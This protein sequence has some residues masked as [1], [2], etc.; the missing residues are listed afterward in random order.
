VTSKIADIWTGVLEGDHNA[1]ERLVSHYA[2]LVF[3][4]ARKTGLAV[5]DAEDCVQQVWLALY[6]GR[7]R[8]ERPE[9]LPAWLVSTTGRKAYRIIRR[10]RTAG[11]ATSKLDSQQPE[12]PPDETIMRWQRRAQLELALEKLDSRCRKLMHAI[13]FAESDKSYQEIARE[14][15]MPLNSLGPTRARCLRKLKKILED[16]DL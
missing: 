16:F 11:R 2:S 3:A 12:M 14:L 8:I 15:G 1:W 6:D 10:K 4:V 9:S 7:H 5:A 13:F